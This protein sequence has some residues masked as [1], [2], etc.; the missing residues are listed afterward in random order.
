MVSCAWTTMASLLPLYY[1]V[2]TA[3]EEI[4]NGFTK[5]SKVNID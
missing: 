5:P 1:S 4:R 3:M 2:V